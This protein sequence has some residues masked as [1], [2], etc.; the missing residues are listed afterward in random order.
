MG[1]RSEP[2]IECVDR[3]GNSLIVMF[4]DGKFGIFSAHL[5]RESLSESDLLDGAEFV[6]SAS[7]TED[8]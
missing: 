6:A 8:L 2:R 4:D 5:L 7:S 1:T 3:L